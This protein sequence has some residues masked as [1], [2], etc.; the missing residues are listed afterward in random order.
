MMKM[1]EITILVPKGEKQK[2][3]VSFLSLYS[4]VNGCDVTTKE[5]KKNGT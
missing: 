5:V 1:I 2:Q 3:I 4:R